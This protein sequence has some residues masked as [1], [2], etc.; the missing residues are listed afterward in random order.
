MRLKITSFLS[1]IPIFSFL[2]LSA[3]QP[4]LSPSVTASP[5]TA[6]AALQ[7][8]ETAQVSIIPTATESITLSTQPYS[9]KAGGYE[10]YFPKDWNC[11]EIG[12]VQVD[13]QPQDG[14]ANITIQATATGYELTQPAF[15]S[16]VNA[17]EVF[18]Y[19]EKKAYTEITR[20]TN[21][22]LLSINAT[23]REGDILWQSEDIFT[24]K[25]AVVYQLSFSAINEQWDKY[26]ALF[27]EVNG[28]IVFHQESL[29]GAPIYAQTRKY[30][31]PD[32]LFTIDV[33]TSWAGYVDVA[34]IAAVQ[35]E[36]FLSPDIH[37]AV[38][39]AVYR[40]GSLIK[41]DAK[42]IKT[43]E[44]MRKLYGS[45]LRI[46]NDK[47]MPDG[48]ERLTWTAGKRQVSGVSYFNSFGFSMYIF[49]IVWDN[50][51][52]AMY[53]PTL[54]AVVNSFGHE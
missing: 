33:P 37:A 53:K 27:D 19:S 35:L 48:R 20:G 39:V 43:L 16:F 54:D 7:S 3:C 46:S 5:G 31:A 30:T 29:S 51:F 40:Q 24:R 28:K 17:E 42:A 22:G 49:S 44:I 23:W 1:T 34:S 36:G 26:L 47:A 50:S 12:Q 21:E 14:M 52:E 18:T 15:E 32:I 38:Q 2:L 41:R 11:S 4:I 9:S 13:C 6:E 25:G 8:E 45:D 10:I